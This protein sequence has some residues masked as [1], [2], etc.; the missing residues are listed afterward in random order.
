MIS[1]NQVK[2]SFPFLKNIRT[3]TSCII[4]CAGIFLRFL[5]I[6]G[7]YDHYSFQWEMACPPVRVYAGVLLQTHHLPSPF[8]VNICL[9]Q[10]NRNGLDMNFSGIITLM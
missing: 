1:F 4:S 9:L 2:K 5:S 7:V 3:K 6:S 8:L 10:E